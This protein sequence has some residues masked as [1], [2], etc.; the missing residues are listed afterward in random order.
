MA[1]P[2]ASRKC[3]RPVSTW[4]VT[5]VP[6]CK[7]NM[8]TYIINDCPECGYIVLIRGKCD[9]WLCGNLKRKTVIYE[10]GMATVVDEDVLL[11]G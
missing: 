4:R 5:I 7:Q 6:F 10:A 8:V 11:Q 9:S 3:R 2:W 1:S